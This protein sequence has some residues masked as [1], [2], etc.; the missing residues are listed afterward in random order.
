MEDIFNS[1]QF[2]WPQILIGS[3]LGFVLS[4]LGVILVLRDMA[5]FGVTLSQ[6]VSCS[7]A[8]SL[9][10]GYENDYIPILFSSVFLLPLLMVHP[11]EGKSTLLGILFVG[12]ASFTQLLLSLGGNVKNHITNAYFGDILTSQV[13]LES[14][15]FIMVSVGFF[16]FVAIY[17]KVLFLSFDRDEF[18][19]RGYGKVAIDLIYYLIITICLSVGV[20][21]L[22]SFYSVAHMLIPVYIAIKFAR[23]MRF[24]F[25]F[26]GIFSLISTLVGFILSLKSYQYHGELIYFPTSSTIVVLMLLS[27]LVIHIRKYIL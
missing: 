9:F 23:S 1:L 11:E 25:V 6:V 24:L 17:K 21:L 4:I 18:T 8:I 3:I 5:F 20:S 2:F 22:G 16:L 10:L 26:S 13:K 7:V 15:G 14:P 12:F 27:A 19:V